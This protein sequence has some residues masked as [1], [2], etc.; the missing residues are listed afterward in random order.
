M[1]PVDITTVFFPVWGFSISTSDDDLLA[2]FVY[3]QSIRDKNGKLYP[4]Q[5]FEEFN[6][7]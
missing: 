2:I 1:T 4:H 7:F 5:I 3:T 6:H